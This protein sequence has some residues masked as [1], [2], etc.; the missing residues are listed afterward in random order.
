MADL[1]P[2]AMAAKLMA[3]PF[4]RAS[5]AVAA[6]SD[7]IADTA[8]VVTLDELRPYDRN[9]RL[10]RNPLY[11]A[12]KDSIRTRGLDSPPQVTRRPGEKH[13]IIRNGG[14]TRL[15]ILRELWAETDRKSTRL[16]SSHH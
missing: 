2:E 5:P 14:N 13:Y 9:P 10:A 16:N 15:A 6:L 8:M 1:T 12:I 3:T 4:E 11:D 7:P